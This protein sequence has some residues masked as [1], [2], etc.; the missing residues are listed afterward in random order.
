MKVNG[1]KRG[2]VSENNVKGKNVRGK[3]VRKGRERRGLNG[4]VG[5]GLFGSEGKEI[6]K[7]EDKR[8]KVRG[9]YERG[10]EWGEG[11]RE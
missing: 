7:Y 9:G 6:K 11:E 2:E 1:S 5:G 8:M 3:R 10:R 4:K